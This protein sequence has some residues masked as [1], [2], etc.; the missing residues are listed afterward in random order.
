MKKSYDELLEENA[1]LR[2]ENAV[3][4]EQVGNLVLVNQ[5]LLERIE[6]LEAR[7]NQNS[8]NSSKPPSSDQKPNLPPPG[9]G[10][11]PKRGPYHAGVSRVLLPEISVTSRE[12]RILDVCPRCRSRMERTGEVHKWQQIELPEI[13]PLVHQIELHTCFCPRCRLIDRPM[14]S[15]DEQM[16]LGPRLEALVNLC[17]GQFRQSHGSVREFIAT[18][19]PDLHLSRGLISKVKAR[20]ARA[21]EEAHKQIIQTVLD[22]NEA[23]HVDVTGWRHNGRN[24]NAIVLR[25]GKWIGFSFAQYQNGKTLAELIQRKGV[26]LVSDRGLA[27]SQIQTRTRQYCLAHLLRNIRGLAEHPSTTLG[28]TAQLGDLHDAI[29]GL[30]VDK[31]RMDRG[32]ITISTWKQ[33]GYATW[34]SIREDTEA[35]ARKGSSKKVCRFCKRMLDDWSCFLTYLRRPENPMTNNPAEEALRSLVITRKLCFGSRSEYGR[36][37]RASLQSCIET[38]RRHG[39]SV[40]NFLTATIQ[41]ARTGSSYSLIFRES[42]ISTIA[43]V[44]P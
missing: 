27:A 35:I 42:S 8:K 19:I 14:L 33:Y 4:R 36:Q 40:L 1:Q 30:F 12:V 7:L 17:L 18:L 3:L 16:L 5:K 43:S 6:K 2:A 15:E 25:S 34:K 29:Q 32:E 22:R 31:H 20:A 10:S 9:S 24:E 28:E 13:K 44:S 41:A 26:H 23:L 11:G 21:L 38:L 37:W 39:Y